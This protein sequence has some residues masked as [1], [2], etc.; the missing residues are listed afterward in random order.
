MPARNLVSSRTHGRTESRKLQ[1]ESLEGRRLLAVDFHLLADVNQT[2]A[3]VPS[4]IGPIVTI[5]GTAYFSANDGASGKELWKSDG[6]PEGTVRVKDIF[7]GAK[8]SNPAHLTEFQGVLYFAATDRVGDVGAYPSVD[9]ELWRSDGTET[10]TYRV[11]DLVPGFRPSDVSNLTNVGGT[12]FFTAATL[13]NSRMS[14]WKSDG[15]DVGTAVIA[16]PNP[17]PFSGSTPPNILGSVGDAVLFTVNAELWRSDG[18]ASGTFQLAD[19]PGSSYGERLR[20]LSSSGKT[21]YFAANDGTSGFGLWKTDGTVAGTLFLSRYQSSYAYTAFLSGATISETLIFAATDPEHGNELWRSDGTPEGTILLKDVW[22]GN[23]SYQ[24]PWGPSDPP[25]ESRPHGFTNVNGQVYFLAAQQFALELWR[26]DGTVDGTAL[27]KTLEEFG[28]N[29]R[30]SSLANVGGKLYFSVYGSSASEPW[31]SDGTEAGTRRLK[32]INAGSAGWFAGSFTAL[33]D[34]ALFVAS[35]DVHGQ[36]LWRSDGTEEGTALVRDI[37]PATAGSNSYYPTGVGGDI[38]FRA[39]G[40]S[41]GEELW[42]SNGTAGTARL[43]KDI[44]PG[45]ES[46][47]ISN[48][49]DVGGVLF[50]TADDG[51]SGVELWKSDGTAAGTVIVR[52]V[53]TG[54]GS[55]NP[56]EFTNVN[57]TLYFA[58]ND[59][60]TGIELWKSDGTETGTVRIKDISTG[61]RGSEPSAVVNVGGVLYFSANDGVTGVELWRSDG[62]EAGT[63]PVKDILLGAGNSRPSWLVN[64]G[65]VLYFSAAQD[66]VNGDLWKSDGTANGT[67]RVK[68]VSPETDRAWPTEL[69]N[70]N[71]EL[72][73]STHLDSN[74]AALWKSDGTEAGTNKLT[75]LNLSWYDRVETLGSLGGTFF[76]IATSFETGTTLWSSDGT[77]AGTIELLF[78]GSASNFTIW[79]DHLYF[80]RNDE[81]HGN[82]L[83]RT[84]GS[85]AGVELAK[86]FSND[87]RSSLYGSRVLSVVNDRLVAVVATDLYGLELWIS[88]LPATPLEGDYDG[89]GRVDSGD[90]LAWQRGF[91][92]SA[93][94]AGSGADG[95]GNGTVGAG[96]LAVWK[97]RFGAGAAQAASAASA[98]VAPGDAAVSDAIQATA[99]AAIGLQAERTDSTLAATDSLSGRGLVALAQAADD[100]TQDVRSFFKTDEHDVL[101]RHIYAERAQQRLN[102]V[103]LDAAFTNWENAAHGQRRRRDA[104]GG[105]APRGLADLPDWFAGA[106]LAES[107]VK[108][109]L[110]TVTRRLPRSGAVE[111]AVSR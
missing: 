108:V 34:G 6:T 17:D 51:V 23:S 53:F 64:V 60:A 65:G 42:V 38:F 13:E 12:L 87:S 73:F 76:I 15:T 22:P 99:V 71:G 21:T 44:R 105:H 19:L 86:D 11:K 16:I 66:G 18:A 49:V 63:L 47:S 59:G 97:E 9:V 39:N 110:A 3:P 94:P 109:S 69:T 70:V 31:I 35:D 40:G 74:N 75:H 67:V 7:P 92:G 45:L 2:P 82:E 111:S 10:G 41:A 83:W 54:A 57:G 72:Y 24:P 27:V 62:S 85:R 100:Q 93:T 26:T 79:D 107:A 61:A 88:D 20:V 78:A 50:F 4:N 5:G 29:P 96:D 55:S 91:G 30:Y 89:N 106:E 101:V 33:G 46:S 98:V 43:V 102:T 80:T 81:Y 103:V 14:L 84:D 77:P 28:G 52:D 32:D 58:A 90:F 68:N 56:R 25:N 104:S 36:E 1:F 8:G 37:L 48:L 95:D